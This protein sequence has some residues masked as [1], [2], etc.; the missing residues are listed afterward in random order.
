MPFP[1]AEAPPASVNTTAE[2]LQIVVPII[3]TTIGGFFTYWR[4]TR[5]QR[6][7]SDTEDRR[8]NLSGFEGLNKA[9]ADEIRRIG[10]ARDDE[11]RRHQKEMEERDAEHRAEISELRTQVEAMRA[12][13]IALTK[14]GQ[15]VVR[16]LRQPDVARL[17]SAS[18]IEIPAPPDGI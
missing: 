18:A 9:L 4:F 5:N 6:R 7:V 17:L 16:V 3:I 14:W 15:A 2:I 8:I 1:F 11:E 13:L 12:Q 10:K